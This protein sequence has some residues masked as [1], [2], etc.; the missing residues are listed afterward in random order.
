MVTPADLIIRARRDLVSP[1]SA[2]KAEDE[3]GC[4]AVGLAAT[5]PVRGYHIL[6]PVEQMHNRGNGKG[7]GVAAVGLVPE[8]MGV[9]VDILKDRY[10][11]QIA[12]IDETPRTDVEGGVVAPVF[13]VHTAYA[14]ESIPD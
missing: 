6:C 9:P 11:L 8:Q 12:Y 2:R 4:G 10:L 14:G 5:V 1:V 13:A 7:G 3:G